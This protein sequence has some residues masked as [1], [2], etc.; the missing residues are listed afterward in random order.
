[1]VLL[2]KQHTDEDHRMFADIYRVSGEAYQG[3]EN[4]SRATM[5]FNNAVASWKKVNAALNDD[6]FSELAACYHSAGLIIRKQ[7]ELDVARVYFM[8]EIETLG[9]VNAKNIDIIFRLQQV[10]SELRDISPAS[11]LNEKYLNLLRKYS[12]RTFSIGQVSKN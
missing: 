2:K 7:N 8:S 12:A 6:E 10:F 9:H 3:I 5:N 11:I 4:W 1:M